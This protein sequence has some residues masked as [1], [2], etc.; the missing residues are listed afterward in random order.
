MHRDMYHNEIQVYAAL[1]KDSTT[2]WNDTTNTYTYV[3]DRWMTSEELYLIGYQTESFIL[4]C[5]Y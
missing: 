3:A 2:S 5:P 1:N 4:S